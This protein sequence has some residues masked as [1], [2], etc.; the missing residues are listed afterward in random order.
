[1]SPL[2][3][4]ATA[5]TTIRV[6]SHEAVATKGHNNDL[7]IS[8]TSLAESETGLYKYLL[9]SSAISRSLPWIDLTN[10]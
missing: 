4:R 7:P 5:A 9:T 1:M 10:I 2:L 8:L 6:I 3:L